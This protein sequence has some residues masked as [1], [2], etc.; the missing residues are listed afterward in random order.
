MTAHETAAIAANSDFPGARQPVYSREG[1]QKCGFGSKLACDIADIVFTASEGLEGERKVLELFAGAAVLRAGSRGA[2][3]FRDG[4]LPAS[5]RFDTIAAGQ[6][7]T[8]R[9]EA[10]PKGTQ[11]TQGDLSVS[12]P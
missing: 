11:G 10:G 7:H 9:L 12:G 8:P 2:F 6:A 3:A 4:L 5:G 1:S